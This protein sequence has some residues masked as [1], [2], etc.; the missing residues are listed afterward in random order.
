MFVDLKLFVL[1]KGKKEAFA[2]IVKDQTRDVVTITAPILSDGGSNT[3]NT[4]LAPLVERIKA[5]ILVYYIYLRTINMF[6]EAA[7]NLI[8]YFKILF[9][10]NC[11]SGIMINIAQL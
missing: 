7:K 10:L 11:Y 2:N 9:Y 6:F 1:T 5:G 3:V 4:Q 8:R